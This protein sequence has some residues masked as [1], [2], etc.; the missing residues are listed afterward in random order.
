MGLMPSKN[1]DSGEE[2]VKFL[3]SLFIE[4]PDEVLGHDSNSLCQFSCLLSCSQVLQVTDA[5][6]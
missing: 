4:L 6:I 5:V 2:G 1:S 3:A